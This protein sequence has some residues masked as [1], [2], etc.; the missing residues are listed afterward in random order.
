MAWTKRDLVLVGVAIR[1]LVHITVPAIA[2]LVYVKF[3][4]TR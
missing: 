2:A 3:H 4:H 1:E